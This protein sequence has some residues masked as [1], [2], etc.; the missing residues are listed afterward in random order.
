MTKVS[1]ILPAYKR[2]FLKEAIASI[3]AQTYRDFELVVVDDCSPEDLKSVV[4]EFQ[5]ERL[6]YHRNEVNIGGRDLVKAWTHAME[7]ATGEWCV[8]AS[9]DDVYHRDYLKE[10]IALTEKYPAV[11]LV[12]CRN[13]DIDSE[14]K[15]TGVGHGRAEYETGI[16][17]LYSSS[18]LRVHQRMADLMFRKSTYDQLGFPQYPIAWYA[19]NATAIEYAWRNG[20]ACSSRILFMFRTS[21]INLSSSH[22]ELVAAKIA[23]GLKFKNWV[24]ELQKTANLVDEEDKLL[25]PLIVPGVDA[26][27]FSLIRLI[28]LDLPCRAFFRAIN[29]SGMPAIWK[30][31]LR[32]E[33]I[34]S[35]LYLRRYLPRWTGHRF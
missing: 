20:A 12:H 14:G 2:R 26:Q 18:V 21:G 23:A 22:P 6:I 5:D 3:L 30:K 7:F 1:F 9:D 24:V 31:W 33:R 19:D 11:D 35:W 34:Y 13:A 10:M 29:Q 4:D 15:I 28:L 17:M 27:V 16:Q 8:L 25:L 32:R